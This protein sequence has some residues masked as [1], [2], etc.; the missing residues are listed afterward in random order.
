M[1]EN[2]KWPEPFDAYLMTKEGIYDQ[3]TKIES[4]EQ[5]H[6]FLV[7]NIMDNYEIRVVDNNDFIVLQVIEQKLVFPL[8]YGMS[9]NNHWDPETKKFKPD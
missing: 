5:L 4:S 9:P 1:P 7:L 8:G 3:P 2:I 6:N